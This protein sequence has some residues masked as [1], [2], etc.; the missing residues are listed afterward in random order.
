MP[1][2]NSFMPWF[3]QPRWAGH[4]AEAVARAP[5]F[6]ARLWIAFFHFVGGTRS[7]RTPSV[8][9][10]HRGAPAASPK[11]NAALAD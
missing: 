3:I 7:V 11:L 1:S 2:R 5:S 8:R 6:P 9:P 10:I 4:K